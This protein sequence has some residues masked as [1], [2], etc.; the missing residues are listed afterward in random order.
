MTAATAPAEGSL[1]PLYMLDT[2]IVSAVV[3]GHAA[4]D[5]KLLAMD[6]SQ[7][8]ISTITYS[9]LVYGLALRPEA[10]RLART[11]GAFLDVA[12]TAPWDDAAARAHGELRASLRLTGKPIGDFDEMIA[13][14]AL[15]L[16]AVLVTANEKHFARVA[17]LTAENWL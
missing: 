12:T 7:W 13:G 15:S 9:E 6:S 1:M 5:A 17:G 2:N 11:V 4:I 14:H 16:G 3:R 8:C 10:T